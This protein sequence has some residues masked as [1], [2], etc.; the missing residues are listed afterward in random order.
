MKSGNKYSVEEIQ[1]ILR[2]KG[3]FTYTYKDWQGEQKT[4]VAN[5][6]IFSKW[7]SQNFETKEFCVAYEEFDVQSI[8]PISKIESIED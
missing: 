3:E 6:I 2:K 8:V 4:T 5:M 7:I 1:E